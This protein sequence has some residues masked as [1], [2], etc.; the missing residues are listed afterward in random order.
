MFQNDVMALPCK[1]I[2]V[3]DDL[4]SATTYM[5]QQGVLHL[6]IKGDNVRFSEDGRPVLIDF[7][8][9]CVYAKTRD[10]MTVE[11]AVLGNVLYCAPELRAAMRAK[12]ALTFSGDKQMSFAIGVIVAGV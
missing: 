10:T 4:L 11:L 3:L 1:M 9:T 2:G 12:S 7:G 6:D 8:K 5:M